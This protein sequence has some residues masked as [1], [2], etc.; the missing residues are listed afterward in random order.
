MPKNQGKESGMFRPPEKIKPVDQEHFAFAMQ[1]A[2]AAS[3]YRMPMESPAKTRISIETPDGKVQKFA[4]V[5]ADEKGGHFRRNQW[6]PVLK[7]A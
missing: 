1:L 3:S 2:S 6:V 7:Q 5:S 4:F